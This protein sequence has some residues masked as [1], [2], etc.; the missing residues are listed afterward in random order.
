MSRKWQKLIEDGE[1]LLKEREFSAAAKVFEKALRVAEKSGDG[2]MRV[3]SL[4]F[5]A[6]ASFE[7]GFAAEAEQHARRATEITKVFEGQ[8]SREY[9]QSLQFLAD[10]LTDMGE[11]NRAEEIASVSVGIIEDSVTS[12]DCDSCRSALM[13]AYTLQLEIV[14]REGKFDRAKSCLSQMW[15]FSRAPAEFEEPSQ[16]R[17]NEFLQEFKGTRALGKNW[18][19][20]SKSLAP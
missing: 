3:D 6:M 12:H 20:Y 9:G 8:A 11:L 1:Q 13:N 10:L 19:R 15:K 7:C 18:L 2:E 4:Q 5:L 16:E 14:L 17:L